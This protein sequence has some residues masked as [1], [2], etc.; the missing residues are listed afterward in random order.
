MKTTTNAVVTATTNSDLIAA[1]NNYQINEII[2]AMSKDCMV[3]NDHNNGRNGKTKLDGIGILADGQIVGLFDTTAYS[4]NKVYIGR[5]HEVHLSTYSVGGTVMRN[6][7]MEESINAFNQS[8]IS[9][10]KEQPML[11][12]NL[13]T[14]IVSYVIL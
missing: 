1:Y 12:F 4:L 3:I 7:T 6:G 10:A 8:L 9:F 14:A 11:A 2:S 13:R 5:D